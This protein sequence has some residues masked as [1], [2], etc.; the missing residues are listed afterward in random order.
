MGVLLVSYDFL[1][2]TY[3]F[4][5]LL[6]SYGFLLLSYWCPT[7]SVLLSYCFPAGFLLL[8]YCFP[9]GFLLGSY[10]FPT[11]NNRKPVETRGYPDSIFGGY[12]AC[13]AAWRSYLVCFV[14][15]LNMPVLD[16][17]IAE[18]LRLRWH[19]GRAYRHRVSPIR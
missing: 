10:R 8:S 14:G 19:Q 3:W 2:R 12:Y 6:V 9:I 5:T 18:P 11:G 17:E 16:D 13:V 4:P 15:Q 1:L 7:G